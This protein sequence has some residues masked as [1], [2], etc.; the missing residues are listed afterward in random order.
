[1]E[2]RED[3][4]H[5]YYTSLPQYRHMT[6]RRRGPTVAIGEQILRGKASRYGGA[7]TFSD[8]LLKD[9]AEPLQKA[10]QFKTSRGAW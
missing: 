2:A 7:G 3:N 5:E 10:W 1:M 6:P 9:G 4:A 8:D